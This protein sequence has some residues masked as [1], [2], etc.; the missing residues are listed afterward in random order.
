MAPFVLAYLGGV[1]TRGCGR[2]RGRHWAASLSACPP[3][4]A[5]ADRLQSSSS[6]PMYRPTHSP[7]A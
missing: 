3:E 1:L 4:R 6:I 2:A 5:I 7:L